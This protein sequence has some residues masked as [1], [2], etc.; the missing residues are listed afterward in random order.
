MHALKFIEQYTNRKFNFTVCQLKIIV[1]NTF[2]K[3]IQIAISTG[4][5]TSWWAGQAYMAQSKPSVSLVST[6]LKER[7]SINC[8]VM[9]Y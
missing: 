8:E 7:D 5:M 9:N 4:I 6:F 3:K 1:M 2:L